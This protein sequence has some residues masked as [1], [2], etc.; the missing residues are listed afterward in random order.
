MGLIGYLLSYQAMFLIAAALGLPLLVALAAIRPADI[1]FA[2]SC[3]AAHP[4]AIPQ[5][6]AGLETT[7]GIDR[8]PLALAP[9]GRRGCSPAVPVSGRS[10][11]ISWSAPALWDAKARPS[12]CPRTAISPSWAGLPT[13]GAWHW[14]SPA[15]AVAGRRTKSW[16][17]PALWES[18]HRRSR[19]PPTA[20]S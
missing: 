19:F 8:Y 18:P 20:A 10:K 7:R 14:C 9:P 3:G 5:S 15:T 13:M 16:L 4:D 6:W 17:A 1:D 2:R 11:A 12:R